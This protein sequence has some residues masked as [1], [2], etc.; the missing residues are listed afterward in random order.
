MNRRAFLL[1]RTVE[2]SP[3]RLELSCERLYVRY[4]DARLAGDPAAPLRWLE[5][6][7]R[8]V[9]ALRLTERAWLANEDLEEWLAPLLASFRAR[10]GEVELG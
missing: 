7:L 3:D 5:G 9:R 10:G 2:P 4:L 6:R 1:L 8:R